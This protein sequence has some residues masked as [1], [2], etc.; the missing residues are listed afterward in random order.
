MKRV[1]GLLLLLT[2]NSEVLGSDRLPERSIELLILHKNIENYKPRN[3]QGWDEDWKKFQK[4]VEEEIKK[5][6]LLQ[7]DGTK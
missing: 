4:Y 5:L 6:N 7:Q 2:S 1:I 3:S